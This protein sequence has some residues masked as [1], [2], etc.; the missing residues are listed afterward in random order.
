V[1]WT[2]HRTEKLE[3]LWRAGVPS[4]TIA[5]MIGAGCTKNMV[6]G[7]AHRLNLPDREKSTAMSAWWREIGIKKWR[8]RQAA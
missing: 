2:D 3:R 6:I 4:S 8:R 1:N 7:K 5:R